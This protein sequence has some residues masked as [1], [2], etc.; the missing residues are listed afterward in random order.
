M[1]C[2]LGSYEQQHLSLE[3]LAWCDADTSN[4]CYRGYVSAALILQD[5]AETP[6]IDVYGDKAPGPDNDSY[7]RDVKV[8][9]SCATPNSTIFYTTDGV[10]QPT[11][12]SPYSVK[13]GST[14][15]W[16]EEGTTVFKAIAYGINKTHRSDVIS[17]SVTIV[18]PRLDDHVMAACGS[19]GECR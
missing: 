7:L 14:F 16:S 17:R 2:A 12:T 6:A 4:Y 10:T 18:A 19:S 1:R 8:T 3:Y 15:V 9:M 13:P 11:D 5:Q